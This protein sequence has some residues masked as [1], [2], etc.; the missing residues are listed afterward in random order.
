VHW[1][2]D[3]SFL[4]EHHF[5]YLFKSGQFFF[6]FTEFWGEKVAEKLWEDLA[7][8]CVVNIEYNSLLPAGRKF[9]KITQNRPNKKLNARENL[10]AVRPPILDKNGR[11]KHRVKNLN[12]PM[13]YYWLV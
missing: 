13:I 6:K 9:C 3:S 11:K 10:A 12:F 7:T 2:N 1:G 4:S 8:V 5:R